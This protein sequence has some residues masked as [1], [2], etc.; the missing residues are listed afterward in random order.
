[1]ATRVSRVLLA[2][3]RIERL[4]VPRPLASETRTVPLTGFTADAVIAFD[5]EH[6][7]VTAALEAG[8]P[9]V[10]EDAH[11][12]T[13]CGNLGSVAESLA[14]QFDPQNQELVAWTIHGSDQR[15]G[16]PVGFPQ[17][18][19]RVHGSETPAGVEVPT[20][21][22]WGGVLVRGV[23]VDGQK[24]TIAAV[25]HRLFLTA[26]SLVARAVSVVQGEKVPGAGLIKEARSAG[27]EFASTVGR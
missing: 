24:R 2:D 21:R 11:S 10:T 20:E 16:E 18:L 5:L 1:M 22:L 27:V 19:G 6:P 15:S 23:G 26:I 8:T 9:V 7:Y 13:L 12:T 17:P 25:D 14:S 3:A 4:G